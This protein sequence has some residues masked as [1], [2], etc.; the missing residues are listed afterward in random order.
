MTDKDWY[1]EDVPDGLKE[2]RAEVTSKPWFDPD[3]KKV[4][5]PEGWEPE[6]VFP[7][8]HRKAGVDRCQ[9]WI[10]RGRQ[11]G[12]QSIR[13]RP[14]C[15]THGGKLPKGLAHVNYKHGR[16]TKAVAGNPDVARAYDL[17]LKQRNLL[18]LS[19][20]IAM[21]DA[22]LD[23]LYEDDVYL[24]QELVELVEKSFALWLELKY[25]LPQRDPAI[26]EQIT[27]FNLSF[28]SLLRMMQSKVAF[29]KREDV[30]TERR[31]RLTETEVKRQLG[32]SEVILK[33]EVVSVFALLGGL[34]RELIVTNV[35][36][37]HER[38]AVIEGFVEIIN[39][40][41]IAFLATSPP[42]K[43]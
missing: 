30:L 19:P 39:T 18:N 23:L 32:T 3:F 17:A 14:K 16:Y 15:A 25:T 36:A 13:G 5:K 21:T 4:P 7:S 33:G 10:S 40:H 6:L 2:Y 38:R 37:T 43:K 1:S 42:D 27:I 24:T 9:Q 26:I 35:S 20:N 29:D 11:C 41:T 31:R 12:K 22:R 28:A 34:F 8:D